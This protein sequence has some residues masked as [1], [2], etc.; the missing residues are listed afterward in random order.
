V[1]EVLA[2]FPV[3]GSACTAALYEVYVIDQ[4]QGT[5]RDA[6]LGAPVLIRTIDQSDTDSYFSTADEEGFISLGMIEVELDY[7]EVK[8]IVI[9]LS[10][11]QDHRENYDPAALLVSDAIMIRKVE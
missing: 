5:A 6:A 11:A 2:H 1:I 7:P 3:S 9:K 8:T 10:P 4:L